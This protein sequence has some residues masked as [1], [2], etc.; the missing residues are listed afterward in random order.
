MAARALR[1]PRVKVPSLPAGVSPQLLV[2]A[3]AGAAG[4]FLAW[5][6]SRGVVDAVKAGAVDP[7]SDNNLAYRGVNAVGSSITGDSSFSLGSWLY[8]LTHDTEA[9]ARMIRETPKRPAAR[10]APF[11]GPPEP[12]QAERE[13]AAAAAAGAT[14]WTNAGWFYDETGAFAASAVH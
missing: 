5:R 8:D 12:T 13:R 3:F 2:I 1:V 10:P 9:E 4:V 7:T 6:L 14:T 11:V